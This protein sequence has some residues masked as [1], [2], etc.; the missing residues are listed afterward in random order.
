MVCMATLSGRLCSPTLGLED[1]PSCVKLTSCCLVCLDTKQRLPG[2]KAKILMGCEYS[3]PVYTEKA[4]HIRQHLGPLAQE[5][6]L[7]PPFL[8]LFLVSVCQ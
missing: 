3:E 1:L 2:S 7:T 4:K 8:P 5:S 6:R